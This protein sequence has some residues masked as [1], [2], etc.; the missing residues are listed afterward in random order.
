MQDSP[1]LPA[2]IAQLRHAREESRLRD[3]LGVVDD[4]LRSRP[5]QEERA[6]EPLRRFDFELARAIRLDGPD[7]TLTRVVEFACRQL[8]IDGRDFPFPRLHVTRLDDQLIMLRPTLP[9]LGGPERQATLLFGHRLL[10]DFDFEEI[11]FVIGRALAQHYLG[12]SQLQLI[13]LHGVEA[14][15]PLHGHVR[16]YLVFGEVAADLCGFIAAGGGREIDACL[17]ALVKTETGLTGV[18][19]DRLE[20]WSLRENLVK[21]YDLFCDALFDLDEV[22]SHPL[23]AVRVKVLTQ[24]WEQPLVRLVAQGKMGGNAQRWQ[25]R[26]AAYRRWLDQ[27]MGRVYPDLVPCGEVQA[28]WEAYHLLL[29]TTISDGEFRDE[30]KAELARIF[31]LQ[32]GGAEG[33]EEPAMGGVIT[34]A[35]LDEM[36]TAIQAQLS[37]QGVGAA[38]QSLLDQAERHREGGDLGLKQSADAIRMAMSVAAA[39][40]RVDPGEVAVLEAYA[41]RRGLESDRVDLQIARHVEVLARGGGS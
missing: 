38:I 25:K 26:T 41:A 9:V 5:G 16:D 37:S 12:I 36:Q 13:A 23:L 34:H 2:A 7:T 33:G 21:Q 24:A 32:E 3:V 10:N 31:C 39:D 4:R 1:S 11:K 15:D 28:L 29:A 30:E 20:S 14:T 17:R 22:R 40:G 19:M 6:R 18:G 35:N 8:G 27:V